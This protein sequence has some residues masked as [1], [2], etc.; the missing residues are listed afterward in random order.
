MRLDNDINDSDYCVGALLTEN[1]NLCE[2]SIE[3]TCDNDCSYAAF[4]GVWS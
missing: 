1:M 2:V 3:V 4:A